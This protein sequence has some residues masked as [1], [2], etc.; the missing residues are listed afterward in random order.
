MV[1][2][3]PPDR[4]TTSSNGNLHVSRLSLK[5]TQED[6]QSSVECQKKENEEEQ[7]KDYDDEPLTA[8]FKLNT[9][10]TVM[11]RVKIT[12]TPGLS[13]SSLRHYSCEVTGFYP[14]D[15]HVYWTLR[16]HSVPSCCKKKWH[17]ADGTF[18]KSCHVQEAV[19]KTN[20]KSGA[21]LLASHLLIPF[22]PSSRQDTL[23]SCPPTSH[24]RDWRPPDPW[25]QYGTH[26]SPGELGYPNSQDAHIGDST[27]KP[28]DFRCLSTAFCG[29]SLSSRH[30]RYLLTQREQPQ[31]KRLGVGLTPSF[32]TAAHERSIARSPDA[33][34][35]CPSLLHRMLPRSL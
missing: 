15:I 28:P 7:E 4:V 18:S 13:N 11:P 8:V 27:T 9:L 35:A 34:T 3:F 31:L 25:L 32:H 21:L 17:N 24:I 30:S 16:N 26:P 19:L 29:S 5:I 10:I 1:N 33:H 2:P 20:N 6:I 14:E 12:T 23:C 22:G